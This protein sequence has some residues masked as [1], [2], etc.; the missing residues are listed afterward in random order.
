MK[1]KWCV[2]YQQHG[3]LAQQ[4]IRTSNALC[5]GGMHSAWDLSKLHGHLL[6]AQGEALGDE[7]LD[8]KCV[9][10][11][12]CIHSQVD[13]VGQLDTLAGKK[14]MQQGVGGG[15]STRGRKPDDISVRGLSLV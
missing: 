15:D 8:C 10:L 14:L 6:V 7:C 13:W 11:Q 1:N 3:V 2:S 5:L 12:G 4:Q 9:V